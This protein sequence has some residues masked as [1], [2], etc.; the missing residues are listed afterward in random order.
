MG[1]YT[2]TISITITITTHVHPA[3]HHVH[4]D[5][6]EGCGFESV[7]C[8]LIDVDDAIM[9]STSSI[10]RGIDGLVSMASD[11]SHPM[12]VMARRILPVMCRSKDR[13]ILPLYVGTT[14]AASS[15]LPPLQDA[16]MERAKQDI[17]GHLEPVCD[18][19]CVL[20]AASRATSAHP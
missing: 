18:H 14:V 20:P 2:I 13:V 16:A 6:T 11:E 12:S 19:G 7:Y 5:G 3:G 17:T 8:R 15:S 10:R 4:I 1:P 9:L